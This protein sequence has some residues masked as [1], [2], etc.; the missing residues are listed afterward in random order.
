MNATDAEI[1]TKKIHGFLWLTLV[2]FLNTIPLLVLSFLA[3]LASV[4]PKFHPA[5]V[6]LMDVSDHGIR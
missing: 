3:N 1:A 4:S 6:R 5:Y 2:C